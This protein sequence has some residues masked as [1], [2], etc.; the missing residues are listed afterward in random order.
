LAIILFSFIVQQGTAELDNT[1]TLS[2][3]LNNFSSKLEN[4]SSAINTS[5]I[6]FLNQTA[7]PI[8]AAAITAASAFVAWAT[9]RYAKKTYQFNALIKAFELLNDNA[10]RNARIRLYRTA[11]VTDSTM[12]DAYLKELGVKPEALK[13]II[14][15]SQNIL[16][17]D[18]DQMGTLIK[19]G[20][21]L[22]KDFL[23]VYWNTVVSSYEV[24][25]DEEKTE[26]YQN[27]KD[28]YDKA[29]HKKE[30]IPLEKEIFGPRASKIVF[31]KKV[32]GSRNLL[33]EILVK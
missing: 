23:D 15:E 29:T 2:I 28:L 5:S 12:R 27:F 9:G 22:Q 1:S 17:A 3:H 21:I 20:F 6:L 18:F 8:I 26:L 7:L 33:K 4:K 14:P 16:L 31:H 24:L 10:H 11:G 32:E 30:N 19:K 25:K 13:T